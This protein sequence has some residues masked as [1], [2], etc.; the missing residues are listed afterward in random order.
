MFLKL[1]SKYN[2]S[3][4]TDN[5]GCRTMRETSD[6]SPLTTMATE[7]LLDFSISYCFKNQFY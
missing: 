6:A 5:L 1:E 7:P 2:I 4:W 3:I